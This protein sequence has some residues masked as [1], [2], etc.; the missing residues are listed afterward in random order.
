M[1]R[2]PPAK[3]IPSRFRSDLKEFN[4]PPL[5]L[6]GGSQDWVTKS[7]DKF[8][9]FV[10]TI[11]FWQILKGPFSNCTQ[12]KPKNP[13]IMDIKFGGTVPSHRTQTLIASTQTLNHLI[14]STQTLNQLKQTSMDIKR[15]IL[16][17]AVGV[18]ALLIVSGQGGCTVF[19]VPDRSAPDSSNRPTE[20][21]TPA[22]L[23][24][25]SSAGST[26]P[27]NFVV[28]VVE[29]VGPAVVRINSTR[30]IQGS[31][32]DSPFGSLFEFPSP[33]G[34]EERVDRGTGSGFIF[35]AKGL[36][37]T[38][39]HVVD[40]ADTVTVLLKDG[41]QFK[42]K[43]LGEDTLTDV[44]VVQVEAKGLPI[45]SLGDSQKL[46]PGEWAIA[47]GNPLGLDN[48]VTVGIISATGRSGADIGISDRRVRYIQT[49][50]AINPGNSGGPLLNAKGQ[51][52]GVNTAILQGA[53]GLGFAIPI[54]TVQAIARQLVETGKVEHAYL[55]VQMVDLTPELRDRLQ[56]TENLKLSDDKGVLVVKIVPNSPA[57]RAG[58]EAGDIIQSIDGKSISTTDTVQE[59]IEGLRPGTIIPLKV[60]RQ[61]QILSLR[62]TLG[63]LP[64]EILQRDR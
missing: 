19:K 55:G 40:Q 62:V 26:L 37:L 28:Q 25:I 15:W 6:D 42:G 39:A 56:Q 32:A 8:R 41:R 59:A 1:H 33:R 17:P 48:T 31:G 53:Q 57:A 30:K 50:A 52:I 54:D 10:F 60:K 38:N 7:M 12:K 24:P 35:D 27:P 36:I 11:P 46:Q 29:S 3:L 43:V 51:V 44:A 22:P 2:H 4:I 63:T 16:R 64:P 58:I 5:A 13:R 34:Q 45:V 49:D 18:M 14:A 23:P 61:R 9:D 21:S 20:G 47:I